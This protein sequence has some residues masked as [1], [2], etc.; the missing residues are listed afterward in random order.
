MIITYLGHSAFIV[1]SDRRVLIF[2]PT[3]PLNFGQFGGLPVICF[4][5]HSHNDHYGQVL[6]DGSQSYENVRWILGDIKSKLPRT[7]IMKGRESRELDGVTIRTAG[8]TDAGVCFLVETDGLCLFHAGDNADWGDP[9]D[10][11]AYHKEID[12]LVRLGKSIDAAFL[13][14]CTFSG[15]RPPRM[16]V[17]ALYAME[18]LQ[19]KLVIPMHGNGRE[20]LYREFAQDAAAKGFTNIHCFQREG[21]WIEV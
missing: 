2:D 3:A 6:H 9:G 8:S 16:T 12:Y 1:Q 17:G 19:P 20:N 13:P 10:E 4:A 18:A 14:V 7:V 11:K 21:E 15:Q 5:S